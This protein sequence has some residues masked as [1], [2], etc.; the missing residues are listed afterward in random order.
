M[1][2]PISLEPS[3]QISVVFLTSFRSSR[4]SYLSIGYVVGYSDDVFLPTNIKSTALA[5]LFPRDDWISRYVG[6]ICGPYSI[7]MATP[8][9]IQAI[10]EGKV[11]E[12]WENVDKQVRNEKF[13]VLMGLFGAGAFAFTGSLCLKRG[14]QI[15]SSGR[16]V[17][18]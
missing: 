14:I 3:F 8:I 15:I 4:A 18:L 12:V 1:H 17:L 5:A 7:R 16:A 6:T 11:P 9:F 13:G 10:G 2:C